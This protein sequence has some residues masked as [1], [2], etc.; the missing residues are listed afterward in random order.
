MTD[1]EALELAEMAMGGNF[2]EGLSESEFVKVRAM[3][4]EDWER[5][6]KW[7]VIAFDR[8]WMRENGI[9]VKDGGFRVLEG[10]KR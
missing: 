7:M 8:R 3:I 9:P 6:A 5:A 2:P 4:T 1:A 10:G